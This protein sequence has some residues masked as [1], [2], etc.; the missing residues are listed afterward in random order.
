MTH[1]D[2]TTPSWRTE[3]SFGRSAGEDAEADSVWQLPADEAADAEPA[4]EHAAAPA[5]APALDHSWL[6]QPL[7]EIS[8]PVPA[9]AVEPVVEASTEPEPEPEAELEPEL[10]APVIQLPPAVEEP[11]EAPELPAVPP[12]AFTEFLVTDEPDDDAEPDAKVPF[13]K[14][15]LS[16]KRKPREKKAREKKPRNK[17][18]E[19][20]REEAQP[21]EVPRREEGAARRRREG[22]V[23]QARSDAA[24]P[25]GEAD[26]AADRSSRPS[27]PRRSRRSRARP[28][29]RS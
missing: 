4:A 26:R 21:E 28:G 17:K 23:L 6:T 2:G 29:S 16:F 14:R 22:A 8:D 5:P 25:Q 10:D 27:S 20:Q 9:A 12:A 15:D 3:L 7:E 1:D 24:A 18:R 19:A 11:V 13:Y